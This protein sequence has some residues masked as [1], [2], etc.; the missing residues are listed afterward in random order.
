VRDVV[1]AVLWALDHDRLDRHS[2]NS[3]IGVKHVVERADDE[4]IV[5]PH[6]RTPPPRYR[7]I[8]MEADTPMTA[9][10]SPPKGRATKKSKPK[11][12]NESKGKRSLNLSIS[13]DTY[14]RLMIHAMRQTNGNISDLVERLATDHLR[15]FHLSRTP[16]RAGETDAT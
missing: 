16:T 7:D 3:R 2:P 12:A 15:E 11:P 4:I 9:Q 8:R 14:E 13:Q 1:R 10:S 5:Y 6:T